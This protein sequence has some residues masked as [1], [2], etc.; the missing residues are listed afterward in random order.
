MSDFVNQPDGPDDESFE[1]MLAKHDDPTPEVRD[2]RQEVV[3]ARAELAAALDQ[4]TDATQSALDV[5]GKIRRNPAKTA[6]LVGGTGSGPA[7]TG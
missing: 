5:P 2:A 3:E 7:L 1:R 4:L 6:A